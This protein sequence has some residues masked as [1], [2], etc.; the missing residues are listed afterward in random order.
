MRKSIVTSFALLAA[1]GTAACQQDMPDQSMESASQYLQASSS[2]TQCP[3]RHPRWSPWTS[4]TPPTAS[5]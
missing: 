4:R 1:L 2:I 5:R 3:G